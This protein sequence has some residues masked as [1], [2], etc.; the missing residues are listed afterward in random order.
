MTQADLSAIVLYHFLSGG[1]M[2]ASWVA[3]IFFLRFWSKT[4]DRLF[5][6]FG[7]SFALL[8]FDRLALV[9]SGTDPEESRP[10]VYF[11]RFIAF[12]IIIWSVI[13]KNRSNTR[14]KDKAA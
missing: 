7:V 12:L 14:G 3:S 8:G 9:L 4:R 13:D 11:L 5:L 10:V 2:V 6:L 1:I